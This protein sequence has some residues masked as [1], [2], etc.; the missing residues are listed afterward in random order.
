MEA[1]A[2]DKPI[3]ITAADPP[4]ALV[5]IKQLEALVQLARALPKQSPSTMVARFI[6]DENLRNPV[7][8]VGAALHHAQFNERVPLDG[9]NV[10]LTVAAAFFPHGAMFHHMSLI[11]R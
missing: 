10:T 9:S 4:N 11:Q 8:Y 7:G 5:S 1:V 3:A 6:R 2:L